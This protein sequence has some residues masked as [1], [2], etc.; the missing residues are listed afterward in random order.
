MALRVPVATLPRRPLRHV[1]REGG[2]LGRG[3]AEPSRSSLA[4]WSLARLSL[5]R[6]VLV[7]PNLAGPNLA[8]PNLAWLR[9]VQRSLALARPPART[10]VRDHQPA[11]A[12]PAGAGQHRPQRLTVRLASKA[13]PSRTQ[14]SKAGP[15]QDMSPA[16]RSRSA[17]SQHNVSQHSVSQDCVSQPGARPVGPSLARMSHALRPPRPR[18][19][20]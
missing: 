20:R 17:L 15:G 11:A 12:V 2:H 9:L 7:R 19:P 3:Q 18:Q 8:G 14:A 6:R 16:G 1:Q 5:V 13:R 10:V 4:G